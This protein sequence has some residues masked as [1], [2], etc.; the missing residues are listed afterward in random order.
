M[1]RNPWTRAL[2]ALVVAG[3]LA[4][5]ASPALADAD[6]ARAF[7]QGKTMRFITQGGAGGGFDVYMRT[8]MPYLE[9]RLGVDIL[10]QNEPGAGGLRAMTTLLKQPAD[11]LTILLIFGEAVIGGQIY[12]VSGARY[13]V[14]DLVWLARAASTPKM[15]LIGPNTPFKTFA[16]ARKLGRTINWG[17]TGKTDGNA[18]FAAIVSH[19]FS[20]PAKIIGGYRG[21]SKML[22]ALEQGEIDAQ[23][24]SDESGARAIRGGKIKPLVILDRERSPWLPDTPTIFEAAELTPE[25]AWWIDWR[26]NVSATGR[27]LLT[28]PGVPADRV[29]LLRAAFHDIFNDPAFLADAKKRKRSISYLGGDAVEALVKKTMASIDK[30]R[31]PEIREVVLKEFYS[32]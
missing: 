18:D 27:L 28:A 5:S 30:S 9:K 2:G 17:S 19:A 6:S 13:E 8:I 25:Q 16:E 12:G 3:A 14:D 26:A 23:V 7:Y 4:V 1:T 11:G 15:I 32:H 24:L 21:S 22:L 31:L 29:A 20:M 10:P